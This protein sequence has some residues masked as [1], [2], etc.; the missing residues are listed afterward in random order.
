MD[1]SPSTWTSIP[2]IHLTIQSLTCIDVCKFVKTKH[3]L[4][5]FN[6]MNHS[7]I[8]EKIGKEGE[9]LLKNDEISKRKAQKNTWKLN[10]NILTITDVFLD[11][12]EH[13]VNMAPRCKLTQEAILPILSCFWFR[14][15]HRN[16]LH[17]DKKIHPTHILQYFK[18]MLAISS[19]YHLPNI[20]IKGKP[21]II[22]L[23][24]SM[25]GK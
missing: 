4:F 12:C 11:V 18:E 3:T 16:L 2:S 5:M 10:W 15:C 19:S 9:F 24:S 21:G 22:I 17:E 25:S 7:K 6:N 14:N 8:L 1:Q 23:S 20:N 13:M